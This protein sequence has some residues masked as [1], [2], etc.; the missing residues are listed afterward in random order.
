MDKVVNEFMEDKTS[1]NFFLK[2][3]NENLSRLITQNNQQFNNIIT[4]INL[5]KSDINIIKKDITDI[6]TIYTYFIN[7]LKEL[8][9]NINDNKIFLQTITSKINA[10]NAKL[11]DNELNIS[12][13][14][15]K[16]NDIYSSNFSI[17]EQILQIQEN[18]YPA[19]KNSATSIILPS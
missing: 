9:I 11:N 2:N 15:D 10:L 18:L 3:I 17:S 6:Q 12:N 4:D 7:V 13:L 8:N 1:I 14:D 5:I 19:N 16:I